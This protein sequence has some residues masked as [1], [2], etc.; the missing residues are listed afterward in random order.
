MYEGEI[1]TRNV[2]SGYFGYPRKYFS[3]TN[4]I[5]EY[6]QDQVEKEKIFQI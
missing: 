4:L 3:T 5:H 6:E 1:A 2:I